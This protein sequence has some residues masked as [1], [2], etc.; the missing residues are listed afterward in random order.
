MRV[1][2]PAPHCAAHILPT[3]L[4][5]YV[6]L[7]LTPIPAAGDAGVLALRVADGEPAAVQPGALVDVVLEQRALTM[8]VQGYQTFVRFAPQRLTFANGQY[9]DLPYPIWFIDPITATDTGRIEL[10]AAINVFAGQEPTMD[11]ADLATLTFVANDV[12]GTTQVDFCP[13][14][15]P[16]QLTGAEGQALVPRLLESGTIFIDGTPPTLIPP[17]TALLACLSQLPPPAADAEEFMARGGIIGDNS[18]PLLDVHLTLLDE[19][20]VWQPDCARLPTRI[21]RTYQVTDAAGNV[22][23]GT[24]VLDVDDVAPPTIDEL[25]RDVEVVVPPGTPAAAATWT[26]PTATDGCGPVVTTTTHTPGSMFPAG[27]TPVTYTF[28]DACGHS[29]SC[30]FDVR[31]VNE[32]MV[33]IALSPTVPGELVRCVEFE[34]W[35][36]DRSAASKVREELIFR[37]GVAT[38]TLYIPSGDY[39]C[40]HARDPLHTLTRTDPNLVIVGPRYAAIFTQERAL[41]L[42]NLNGDAWIDVLDFGVFINAYGL[43][44]DDVESD[45]TF[46][47]PHADLDGDGRVDTHDFVLLFFNH[48]LGNDP[49][50]CA[51]RQDT[52]HPLDAITTDELQR[53]GLHKLV[54]CDVNGD[55]WLDIADVVA[56]LNGASP[57]EV[58]PQSTTSLPRNRNRARPNY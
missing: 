30:S 25:P 18:L 15:P 10:A 5:T 56:V 37:D 46:D 8:P 48:G 38:A 58:V 3:F 24:R 50:C 16:S 26:P 39:T 4:L 47:D 32:L 7:W 52:S 55:G 31:V 11:D 49:G 41:P 9:T 27:A 2:Q 6:F 34:L 43:L 14:P 44:T 51:A 13:P 54:R 29:T 17:P 36:C 35:S 12:E 42:G 28:T 1:L 57:A 21:E 23:T 20:T 45:C 19:S 33:T 40:I 53:R 22:A